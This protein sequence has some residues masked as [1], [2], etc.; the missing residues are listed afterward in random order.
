MTPR[1]KHARRR[2]KAIAGFA[3]SMTFALGLV[4]SCDDSLIGLTR[5]VDPCGTILNC[6]PGSF[7]ANATHINDPC[8]DPACVVPGG[9]GA[10]TPPLGTIRD[11]PGC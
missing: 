11:L 10:L 5:Y 6:P 2:L 1:H 9:C 8:V 7:E 3:I 4:Q